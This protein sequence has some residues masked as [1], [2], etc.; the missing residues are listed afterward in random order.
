MKDLV[1]HFKCKLCF[2]NIQLSDYMQ[3]RP[4]PKYSIRSY[5]ANNYTECK[6]RTQYLKNLYF[7][8]VTKMWNSLLH[9]EL[10][11]IRNISFFK[12]KLKQLFKH[13]PPTE[14]YVNYVLPLYY[15]CILIVF[16]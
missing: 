8:R 7:P 10:K 13:E 15:L 2:Y 5:N 3:N 12:L 6:C 11:G 1:F 14:M 9:K 16:W 4:A